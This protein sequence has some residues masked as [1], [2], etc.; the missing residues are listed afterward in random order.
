[1]LTAY[2]PG[3]AW[4]AKYNKALATVLADQAVVSGDLPPSKSTSLTQIVPT[5]SEA[6]QTDSTFPVDVAPTPLAVTPATPVDP[7][8]TYAWKPGYHPVSI[9]FTLTNESTVEVVNDANN[10]ATVIG[11]NDRIYRATT[12]D[13]TNCNNFGTGQYSLMPNQTVVGCVSFD[14]PPAVNVSEVQWSGTGDS[15]VQWTV[16]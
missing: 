9:G 16:G 5:D 14:L 11:S 3:R 4:L 6:V 10:D 2:R 15:F 7:T 8:D 12:D 13:V 1:M